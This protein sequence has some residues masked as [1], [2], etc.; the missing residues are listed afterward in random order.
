MKMEKFVRDQMPD[1]PAV[2]IRKN[3][4]LCLNQKAIEE[5][6]LTKMRFASLHFDRDEVLLGIRPE[7][8]ETDPSCFRISKEKGRTFTLNCQG[9]LKH[10]KIPYRDGSTVLKATWDEESKMILVKLE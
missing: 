5:F 6:A 8:D 7:E 1:V 10:W 9:F 4:S 3:G 2:T